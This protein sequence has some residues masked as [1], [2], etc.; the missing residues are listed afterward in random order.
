MLPSAMIR[1]ALLWLVVAM[2]VNCALVN[3]EN[4]Q[5]D[6]DVSADGYKAPTL[7]RKG[8]RKVFNDRITPPSNSSVQRR[9]RDNNKRRTKRNWNPS[10]QNSRLRKLSSSCQI[11]VLSKATTFDMGDFCKETV[12][13]GEGSEFILSSPSNM[14][15]CK[16]LQV[17]VDGSGTLSMTCS[18]FDAKCNRDLLKVNKKRYCGSKS[19]S[20]SGEKSLRIDYKTK[21]PSTSETFRCVISVGSSGGTG[22]EKGKIC[23]GCGAAKIDPTRIVGGQEAQKNE[24]PWMISLMATV[25][26]DT[27]T[28][29]ASLIAPSWVLTAS[30]C[31]PGADAS[32]VSVAYGIHKF[33]DTYSDPVKADKIIIHPDYNDQTLENDIAL[34]HLETPV[35][36]SNT[37]LPVCLAASPPKVGT[38]SVV[39][40]WGSLSYGGS[41]P[42]FLQ[43]V[44]VDIVSNEEC[45]EAY[46]RDGFPITDGMICAAKRNKDSCSGDSG[47]PLVVESSKNNWEQVGIVSFG[48][49]CADKDYPGVY[50]RVDYYIDWI[51]SKVNGCE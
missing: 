28:C 16:K 8:I 5:D 51:L 44:G 34:V 14:K 11:N 17:K 18:V 42:D 36:F 15:K 21:T 31:L 27:Y 25:R 48:F 40:G 50:A 47:G 32:D 4:D 41:Y 45:D 33:D 37:V 9:K 3:E 26:G 10:N 35:P 38:L 30:H 13:L 2:A 43:E 24:Y 23:S 19:P 22:S 1:F 29:G 12:V 39:S 6:E 20:Y 46:G 49:G 7:P